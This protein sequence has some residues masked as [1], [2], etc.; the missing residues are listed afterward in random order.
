MSLSVIISGVWFTTCPWLWSF[1]HFD[2]FFLLKPKIIVVVVLCCLIKK[3]FSHLYWTTCHDLSRNNWIKT[4]LLCSLTGI[5]SVIHVQHV[6]TYACV[7]SIIF[8]CPTTLLLRSCR[9]LL[10]NETKNTSHAFVL[11]DSRWH[12]ETK[13]RQA[14]GTFSIKWSRGH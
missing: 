14:R 3:A 10:S 5:I 1:S 9:C 11:W 6:W 7:V 4:F 12:L 13:H 2:F 8:L